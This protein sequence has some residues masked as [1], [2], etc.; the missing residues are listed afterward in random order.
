[1]D[2]ISALTLIIITLAEVATRFV[3]VIYDATG[4]NVYMTLAV[5][6]ALASLAAIIATNSQYRRM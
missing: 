4:G 6:V 1:M 2:I 3:G 5:L